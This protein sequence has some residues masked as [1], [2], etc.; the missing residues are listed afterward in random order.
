MFTWFYKKF[1][2]KC[3]KLFRNLYNEIKLTKLGNSLPLNYNIKVLNFNSVQKKIV[4]DCIDKN[5]IIILLITV[6]FIH[7]RT[8]DEVLFP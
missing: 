2:D 1:E 7:N 4:G 6:D 5:F 8:L 3:Y